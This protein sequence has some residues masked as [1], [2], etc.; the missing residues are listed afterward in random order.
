MTDQKPQLHQSHLQ[1]LYRC[2]EKFRRVVLDGEKEPPRVALVVGT[3]THAV[4][5]KNLTN[6]IQRGSLL[7]REAVQDFA[8]D[9]FIEEWK[10]APVALTDE[11]AEEGLNRTRDTALDHT[12]QLASEYHYAIAPRIIP[13][14]VEHKWVVVVKGYPFDL[15]GS[16]DVD[17]DF[18][19]DPD[20]SGLYMPKRIIRIRDTKTRK[21]NLGQVEVDRSEQYT[22]YALAKKVIDGVMPTEVVQDNLIKPTKSRGPI[23]VSYTST[24][25]QDDLNVFFARFEAAC[26]IIERAAFTPANPTDWWCSKEFCGFAADGSCPFFNSK[27]ITLIRKRGDQN[28]RAKSKSGAELISE[29][30]ASLAGSRRK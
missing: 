15:A 9:A 27:R 2:G 29:L 25:T 10:K 21:M 7:T 5:A 24:R 19:K 23:A 17:E 14:S 11:E 3:S 6:K 26:K 16:W 18:L 12:V 28:A 30:S 22:V 20:R 13:R 8:H 1:I 4:N